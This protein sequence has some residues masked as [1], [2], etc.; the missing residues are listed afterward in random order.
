[1]SKIELKSI[2][3][4]YTNR[5]K[6]QEFY[7]LKNLTLNAEEG[8]VFVLLGPNG[9]GKTTVINIING[10]LGQTNGTVSIN[11]LNPI[12]HSRKIKQFVSTV[13]QETSLYNDLTGR[14]NLEFHADYYGVGRE[15]RNTS[16]DQVLDLVGLLERQHDRVGAYSGGM[17]RRLTLARAL[18]TE[19]EIILLDEPTLGVDVQSRNA[20]W[21]RIRLLAEE[22]KTVFLTTNY[23][24]EADALADFISIIDAGENIVSGTPEE[25]KNKTGHHQVILTYSNEKSSDKAVAAIQD[26]YYAEKNGA[27]VKVRIENNS[28]I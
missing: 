8:Q 11:G 26:R 3:K 9:S 21:N 6:R 2:D 15:K 12:E 1:M 13:P 5:R 28:L 25:L 14:E 4:I 27:T 19:P 22:G 20:I 23:M 7:A 18:L 17:Q 16:I 24:E 10:L